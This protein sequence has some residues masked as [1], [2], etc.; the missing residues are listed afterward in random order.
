M[1]LGEDMYVGH[2][3]MPL[4]ESALMRASDRPFVAPGEHDRI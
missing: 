3:R 2:A 1:L 4:L